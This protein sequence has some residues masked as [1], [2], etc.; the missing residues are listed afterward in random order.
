MQGIGKVFYCVDSLEHFLA[1]HI[2]RV[3]RLYFYQL[4]KL[5][6]VQ[7]QCFDLVILSSVLEES[8]IGILLLCTGNDIWFIAMYKLSI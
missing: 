3:T 1:I 4:L 7:V 2:A 8:P 6:V 5:V